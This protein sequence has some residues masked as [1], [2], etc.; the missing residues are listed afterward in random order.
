V[1]WPLDCHVG[2][3]VYHRVE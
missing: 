2:Y 3:D 1:Q